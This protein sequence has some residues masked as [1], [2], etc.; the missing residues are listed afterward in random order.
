MAAQTRSGSISPRSRP[1]SLARSRSTSG[2]PREARWG[3]SARWIFWMRPWKFVKLPSF[4]ANPR[5][6]RTPWASAVVSVR[7]HAGGHE[8]LQA[9]EG[10]AHRP[11]RELAHQILLEDEERLQAPIGCGREHPRHVQA[12]RP[13]QD[14][15]VAR[16]PAVGGLVGAPQDPV[17]GGIGLLE[18]HGADPEVQVGRPRI[19]RKNRRTRNSSSLVSRDEAMQP[20]AE[21]P[22]VS[23]TRRIA[24][25]NRSRRSS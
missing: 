4:S 3:V 8:K 20:T 11:V 22:C 14:V 7:E 6:G 17:L 25:A 12:P 10:L 19:S 9:P 23:T 16:P 2:R 24:R 1:R 15:E 18:L 21:G 13:R 5:A